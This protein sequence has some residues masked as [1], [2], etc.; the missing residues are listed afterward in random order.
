MIHFQP[1]GPWRKRSIAMPMSGSHTALAMKECQ[2]RPMIRMQPA[3]TK[4]SARRPAAIARMPSKRLK[5]RMAAKP[6]TR[7]KTAETSMVAISFPSTWR[8]MA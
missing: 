7:C 3:K 1:T 8:A 5:C 4:K 2:H 6:T